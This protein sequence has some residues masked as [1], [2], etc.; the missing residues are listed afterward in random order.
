MDFHF[1]LGMILEFLMHF[2]NIRYTTID[3]STSIAQNKRAA[4][5]HAHAQNI[6]LR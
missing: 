4:D 3:I 2:A 6:D 5:N 1:Y